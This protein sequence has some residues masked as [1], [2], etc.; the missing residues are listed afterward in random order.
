MA[1]LGLKLG[2][3]PSGLR[4]GKIYI[5][6]DAD[7]DGNAISASLL[8]FFAKFWPALFDQGRIFKVMTPLVVAKKGKEIKSFYT[9]DEYNEWEN[10]IPDNLMNHF[11]RG[12]FDGDGCMYH[13]L[14]QGVRQKGY[15]QITG[16]KDFLT[17]VS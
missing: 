16:S 12:V 11:I 13:T 14:K 1:S 6:T 10:S 17:G 5:Y 9:K 7:P 8:N 15:F 2:E 3:V 4:Y